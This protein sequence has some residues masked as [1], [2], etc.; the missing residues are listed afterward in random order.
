MTPHWLFPPFRPQ[1]FVIIYG[2][3]AVFIE[4]LH[5]KHT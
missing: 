3:L 1:I 5:S 2:I 4:F